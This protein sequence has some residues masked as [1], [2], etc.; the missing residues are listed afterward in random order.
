M[1]TLNRQ[2]WQKMIDEDLEW[3][4]E[5]Q[6]TLERD[7]IEVCLKFHRRIPPHV[8]DEMRD[9]YPFDFSPLLLLYVINFAY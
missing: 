8:L 6:R 5:Q 1:A 9:K 4:W 7:H 3:L 2:A